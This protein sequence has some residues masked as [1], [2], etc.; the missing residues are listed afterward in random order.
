MSALALLAR[1]ENRFV[2]LGDSDTVVL[3]S[4]AIPGNENNVNRVIDGLLR[5]GAQVVHSGV[6]DVHATGHA[7]ADD[8]KT[9]LSIVQPEWFVPVHGNTDT[10]LRTLLLVELWVS[11]MTGCC[12]AKTV[13]CCCSMAM[14]PATLTGFLPGMSTS[15]ASSAMLAL[16]SFATDGCSPKKV[17]SLLW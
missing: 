10:L 17:S 11:L 1:G 12:C 6:A 5:R 4:H 16:E 9:Y 14:A 7:Q 15:T 2:Q 8:I 3:S 13:M